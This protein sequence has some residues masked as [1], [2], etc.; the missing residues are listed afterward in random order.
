MD[1]ADF[2]RRIEQLRGILD[3]YGLFFVV[4]APKSGTTWLQKA[5]DAHPQIVCA[6][7]GHFAD[8]FATQLTK[9]Y[10]EYFGRQAIVAK[11]VYEGNPYYLAA[12]TEDFD[13][14]VMCFV[15]SAIS[16]LT[17]PPGTSLIGDK[18]PASVYHINFLHRVFPQAKFVNI[19][20][21]GRDTMVSVF[22][23]AH[24]AARSSDSTAD[25]DSLLSEKAEVYAQRW[26][27]ALECAEEFS[28]LHPGAMYTVRYEDLKSDFAAA[29]AGVL[30]FLKI[31]ASEKAIA[32]C[33][34]ETS[35]KRLSAGREPGQEDPNSFVRKGIVGDWR[36]NLAPQYIDIFSAVGADWIER[37]G[38]DR[39]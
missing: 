12:S 31:N 10:R 22:A 39:I 4:G 3:K 36:T 29:F 9:L 34:V 19:V 37:M 7:E 20:R 32:K 18:T 17:F 38:Y 8:N 15:L 26:V 30:H 28:S 24:R 25:I 14:M 21:D 11:H 6:G 1:S 13:F 5:L 16:R 27:K 2:G 23:D 35:F 33:Q